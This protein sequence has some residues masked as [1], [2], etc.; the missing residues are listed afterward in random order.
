M[1]VPSR[2]ED[3]SCVR[4]IPDNQ[5]VLVDAEVDQSFIVEILEHVQSV[6][7]DRSAAFFFSDLAEA[8]ASS[9]CEIESKGTFQMPSIPGIYASFAYGRMKVAKHR[10]AQD[11]ANL[12]RVLLVNVRLPQK[13]TDMLITCN[14]PQIVN[15]QSSTNAGKQCPITS[16][17]DEKD[18]P[19]L[20][21][22]FEDAV[23]SMKIRDWNLFG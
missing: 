9:L 10:D 17:V 15:P 5:E 11:F 21:A 6:A 13:E 7:D 23:R 19:P 3:V 1:R 14:I 18:L 2:F 16:V 12:L 4:E 22:M 8:S 20:V